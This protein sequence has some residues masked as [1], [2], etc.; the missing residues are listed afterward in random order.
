MREENNKIPLRGVKKLLTEQAGFNPNND[1]FNP[2]IMAQM[3]LNCVYAGRKL[4]SGMFAYPGGSS[5]PQMPPVTSA[6]VACGANTYNPLT[7]PPQ[8]CLYYDQQLSKYVIY[9]TNPIGTDDCDAAGGGCSWGDTVTYNDGSTEQIKF[10]GYEC[11]S[12]VCTEYNNGIATYNTL[13]ACGS[14]GC[15]T[16]SGNIGCNDVFAFNYDNSNGGCDSTGSGLPN[17]GVAGPPWDATCCTYTAGCMDDRIFSNNVY[18]ATNT[19]WPGN[20]GPVSIIGSSSV[21]ADGNNIVQLDDDTNS[22]WGFPASTINSSS[23]GQPTC[24]YP[25]NNAISNANG[26]ADPIAS[27]YLATYE[28]DCADVP[29]LLTNDPYFASQTRDDSCCTYDTGCMNNQACNYDDT[30]TVDDGSCEFDTCSGCM[31]PI[32]T[33]Y[34]GQYISVPGTSMVLDC[35]DPVTGVA[36]P[37]LNNN[38]ATQPFGNDQCCNY[39]SGC[40][41]GNG[42]NP[43]PNATADCQGNMIISGMDYVNDNTLTTPY[44]N[45]PSFLTQANGT[46]IG[47]GGV[48]CCDI[49][50]CTDST[51]TNY[52]SSATIDDGSCTYPPT[53]GCNAN[54]PIGD[55]PDINGDCLDGSN[56]NWPNN[57]GCGANNGYFYINYD[58]TAVGCGNPPNAGDQTCCVEV[59]VIPPVEGC[60]DDGALNYNAAADGCPDM[61]PTSTDPSNLDGY[62]NLSANNNSCCMYNTFCQDANALNVQT[63]TSGSF[64]CNNS[65]FG[66]EGIYYG[67]EGFQPIFP[68]AVHFTN[69]PGTTPNSDNDCCIYPE[70]CTDQYAVN[71]DGSV[72]DGWVD[73]GSCEY[74]FGCLESDA[75]N[76][77]PNAT[78]AC[79]EGNS[80]PPVAPPS[81]GIAVDN[82]DATWTSAINNSGLMALLHP[83]APAYPFSDSNYCCCKYGCTDL[84]T[85]GA[86]NYDS[87]ATC[88]DGSCLY[89]TY[90]C[91]DPTAIPSSY[92]PGVDGC[93]AQDGSTVSNNPNVIALADNSNSVDG[94]NHCCIYVE[95]EW[96]YR[97]QGDYT[98]GTDDPANPPLDGWGDCV[99]ILP[100]DADYQTLV[101]YEN[102]YRY[103][104]YGTYRIYP[105]I[106]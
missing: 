35:G 44:Y 105:S 69:E 21:V 94:P 51:A 31:D 74:I 48:N 95:P 62:G 59:P 72:G 5:M 11:D 8:P 15:A 43:N 81:N 55:N 80:N 7:S 56:V 22:P 28:A 106:F 83:G 92:V 76:Y 6:S 24:V 100:T 102:Q 104:R 63:T 68:G 17:N 75:D 58:P 45:W 82:N 91:N 71:F 1:S 20:V 27:N 64:P 36:Q 10:I 84:D 39:Q 13:A 12:N 86:H 38:N 33:D 25:V 88:D 77:D 16:G 70:G 53:Q 87:D 9:D 98:A 32:A 41:D 42:S 65:D 101:N 96:T 79:F 61:D 57:G 73:D 4:M 2:C 66:A 90:G 49:L 23:F 52:N 14:S 54:T 93:Q 18:M 97:C 30:A 26:C 103:T 40:M 78:H 99:E 89:Y 34:I 46:A 3:D 67:E 85:P 60:L 19:D 29:V 37:V 47:P 50:G